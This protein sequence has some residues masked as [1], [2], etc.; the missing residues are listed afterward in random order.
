VLGATIYLKRI[1]GNLRNFFDEKS[2][3]N[4]ISE[5]IKKRI[6]KREHKRSWKDSSPKIAK[7]VITAVK[8][9]ERRKKISLGIGD[10]LIAELERR[11]ISRVDTLIDPRNTP[12]I[13]L[14]HN[15]GFDFE[16][17]GKQLLASLDI[18]SR[19]NC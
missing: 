2:S 13:N 7:I 17:E 1:A 16:K 19:K 15:L 4:E 8:K 18:N 12:S 6:T 14:S 11:G 3:N 5:S 9:T 10:F